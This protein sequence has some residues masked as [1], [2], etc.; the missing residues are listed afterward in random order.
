[1][2][3]YTFEREELANRLSDGCIIGHT[4]SSSAKIW[5]RVAVAGMYTL[6]VSTQRIKVD[7]YEIGKDE[8]I[9]DY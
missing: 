2:K 5:V 6:I 1:M 8:E 4:T 7:P 3:K 9:E